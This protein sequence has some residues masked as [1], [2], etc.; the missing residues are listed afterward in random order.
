MK[1]NNF[2]INLINLKLL[3]NEFVQTKTSFN[4]NPLLQ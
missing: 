3:F 1:N 4:D 2:K